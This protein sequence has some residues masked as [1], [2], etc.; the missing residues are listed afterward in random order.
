MSSSFDTNIY[1]VITWLRQ[2]VIKSGNFDLENW[3]SKKFKKTLFEVRKLTRVKDPNIFLPLIKEQFS[4]CGVCFI[5]SPIPK[6]C[7]ASGATFFLNPQKAIMI[8]SFRHKTDDH[9]WFSLFHE[10]AHL[11]LH[12]K[13]ELIIEINKESISEINISEKEANDFSMNILIPDKYKAE[14]MN[15]NTKNWREIV[16]FAKKIDVSAGILV[17]QLQHLG[18]I[19]HSHYNK[20]KTRYENKSIFIEQLSSI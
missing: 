17:G 18:L 8:M 20:L 9:F 3:N 6:K 2:G 5:V 14:F 7:H 12:G 11:L 10:A 16:R 13:Q 1:S 4:N 15:L 19:K